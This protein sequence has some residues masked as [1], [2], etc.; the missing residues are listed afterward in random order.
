MPGLQHCHHTIHNSLVITGIS[1]LKFLEVPCLCLRKVAPD[2]SDIEQQKSGAG[3]AASITL[4]LPA[5]RG[6]SWPPWFNMSPCL[7]LEGIW[8]MWATSALPLE[9][10]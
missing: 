2:A 5:Q 6:S 9:L 1:T 3:L 7:W 8:A 4:L 10:A